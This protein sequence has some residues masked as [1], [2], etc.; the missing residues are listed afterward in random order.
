MTEP[1]PDDISKM[2]PYELARTFQAGLPPAA[3]ERLRTFDEKEINNYLE[4]R[5]VQNEIAERNAR[6]EFKKNWA[7]DHPWTSPSTN[8]VLLG[9]TRVAEGDSLYRAKLMGV[10]TSFQTAA[11]A[12]DPYSIYN[13]IPPDQILL[14]P[15][16]RRVATASDFDVPPRQN[17]TKNKEKKARRDYRRAYYDK[18]KK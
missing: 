17:N 6:I 5:D 10:A 12:R 8:P 4:E 14:A 13:S 18:K 3:I 7:K 16:E 11:N 1:S 15:G 9:E 2:R